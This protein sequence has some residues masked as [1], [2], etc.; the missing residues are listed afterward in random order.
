MHS[1]KNNP[2]TKQS[3]AIYLTPERLGKLADYAT[4][5]KPSMTPSEA[6]YALIDT[7]AERDLEES[8]S[9]VQ[10]KDQMATLLKHVKA[11]EKTIQECTLALQ[12]TGQALSSI[13]NSMKT[14]TSEGDG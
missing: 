5:M 1:L 12:A 9:L 10:M 11:Q 4:A 14:L 8:V 6:I 7:A 2:W 13:E 3:V